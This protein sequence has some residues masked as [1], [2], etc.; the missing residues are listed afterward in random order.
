M[1]RFIKIITMLLIERFFRIQ[2]KEWLQHWHNIRSKSLLHDSI[3]AITKFLRVRYFKKIDKGN[4]NLTYKRSK[5]R[6]SM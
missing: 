3:L 1:E 2:K 5:T 4:F 6:N